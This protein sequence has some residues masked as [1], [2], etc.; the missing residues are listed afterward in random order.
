MEY[1]LRVRMKHGYSKNSFNKFILRKDNIIHLF[2]CNHSFKVIKAKEIYLQIDR[3]WLKLCEKTPIKQ[4][5][6]LPI[7]YIGR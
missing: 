7:D 4:V 2:L 1:A 6:S 5:L 3:V